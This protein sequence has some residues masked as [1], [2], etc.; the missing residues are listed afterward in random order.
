MPA[1]TSA[2]SAIWGTHFGL[3][4]AE[5]SMTGRFAAPRRLTNSILS[6]VETETCSFCRPSRG[7]TSTM[8]TFRPRKDLTSIPGSPQ[9]DEDG[10]RLHQLTLAT[11][12]S[13]HHGIARRSDWQF[14]FHG[15]EDDQG[16]AFLDRCARLDQHFEHGGRHRRRERLG[17][18]R[19]R[20]T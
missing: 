9:F 11:A 18:I 17:D 19:E 3:T 13:G 1:K 7:P 14:H 10:V 8:V 16:V 20:G 6:A 15:L 2:A 12:H 5:T 4:N